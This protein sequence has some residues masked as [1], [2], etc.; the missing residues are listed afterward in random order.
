MPFA[1]I[2][3]MEYVNHQFIA[4]Q[5]QAQQR[6]GNNHYL[7]FRLVAAQDS[8]DLNEIMKE[9]TLFGVQAAYSYNTF[10]GPIGANLGYNN[11]TKNPYFFLNLGYEF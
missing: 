7:Q 6:M 10:F 5:L 1:G 3:G 11:R 4:V 9:K 8:E 2:G